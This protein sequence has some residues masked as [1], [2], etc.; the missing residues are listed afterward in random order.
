M[1]GGPVVKKMQ[2]SGLRE[3]VPY[4]EPQTGFRPNLLRDG[5]AEKKPAKKNASDQ[6]LLSEAE[7]LTRQLLSKYAKQLQDVLEAL[8]EKHPDCEVIGKM[9]QHKEDCCREMKAG[10]MIYETSL[11]EMNQLSGKLVATAKE[12]KWEG[13]G[14]GAARSLTSLVVTVARIRL[15]LQMA[16]FG[17]AYQIFEKMYDKG[18]KGRNLAEKTLMKDDLFATYLSWKLEQLVKDK[19]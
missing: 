16:E 18:E 13:T 9:M 4:A 15:H 5:Q 17:K 7:G 6:Q 2:V 12:G 8:A 10:A 14:A 11:N 3:P 1:N 19:P